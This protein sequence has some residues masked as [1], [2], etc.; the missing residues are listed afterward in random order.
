MINILGISI[1]AIIIVSLIIFIIKACIYSYNCRKEEEKKV[2]EIIESLTF[3]SLK[4]KD[5]KNEDDKALAEIYMYLT[6]V[7][8]NNDRL[9]PFT[10]KFVYVLSWIVVILMAYVFSHI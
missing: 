1:V 6:G 4:C 5:S 2:N 9:L 8:K 3:L 10:Y 7:V